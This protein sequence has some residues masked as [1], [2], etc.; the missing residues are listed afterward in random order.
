MLASRSDPPLALARLRVRGELAEIRAADLRFTDSEAAEL[1]RNLAARPGLVL[2]DSAAAAL[3]ARTEGWAAG[4]QLAALSL[5]GQTDVATFVAAF[6]GSHRYVLDYLA[7]EVLEC[8][9]E[10]VRSFLLDTSI[11]NALNGGLCDAVTG[12]RD[13]Q[14]MLERLERAGLF[15]APLDDVR[16]WWR[17]H[18]LF[19]DLLQARLAQQPD[20]AAQLH[21]KAAGWYDAHDMADEAVR[22]AVAGRDTGWAARLIEGNFDRTYTLRGEAA[23]LREWLA[24]LPVA[25]IWTRPRLLLAQ[26]QLAAAAAQPDEEERLVDAAER[27]W[28]ETPCEHFQPPAGS[29]NSLLVNVPALIAID[30]SYLAIMR[31]DA[32]ATAVF[33]S[34]ALAD[35]GEDEQLLEYIARCN[36]AAAEWLQGRLSEAELTFVASLAKWADEPSMPV[37]GRHVFGR[38]QLARGDLD[39]AVQTCQRALTVSVPP[40]RPPLPAAGPAHVCLGEIAYQRDQLDTAFDHVTEG[41]ALCRR[42]AYT[43]PLAAGLVTLAWIRHAKGDPAGAVDAIGAATQVSPGPVGLLNPVPAHRARLLLAQGEVGG[44]AAWVTEHGFHA[45]DEPDY[46]HE[47]G[48]L[49]LA[50]VLLAQDEP[51]RALRV[52]DRLRGAAEGQDRP[53]STMAIQAL[54]GLAL[55]AL[56]DQKGA[57]TAVAAAVHLATP[58]GW[59]RMFA[60]EGPPM[61]TLLS[62]LVAAP[63][64]GAVA[65]DIPLGFLARV[66]RGFA[67][68]PIADGRGRHL[69]PAVSGVVEPLTNRELEV[70]GMLAAGR[71]NKAIAA[72]LVVSLDTVKKHV[73][74][75]LEKLGATNRTEAVAR[76]RELGLIDSTMV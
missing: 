32:K 68:V 75:L 59:V 26:A 63:L 12:S 36:L 22:H 53:A 76:A 52:L 64:T 11:L 51:D 6:R 18:Q 60:D 47:Q 73:S 20:R 58:Q 3:A 1:L 8:Q 55:E 38:I 35:L 74:H 56:G 66:Q 10:Q 17:Y 50:R 4:L 57:L 5:R 67:P 19:A 7:E 33:A 37:W 27:A 72:Q 29:D 13:S 44:A 49:I 46:A 42:L 70:L 69:V 16:G 34:W 65:G 2:P 21:R 43:P 24:A 41:I 48:Y 45:D 62:R 28:A 23:T 40:G 15:L 54:R 61:A 31:G 71:T 9:T 25:L 14:E 30:R 39:G